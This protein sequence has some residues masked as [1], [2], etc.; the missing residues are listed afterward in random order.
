QR[1]DDSTEGGSGGPSTSAEESATEEEPTEE[2]PT[3]EEPT[4]DGGGGDATGFSED[5]CTTY[6]LSTFEEVLGDEIDPDQTYTSASSSGETGSVS[7]NFYTKDYWSL[8]LYVD[9]TDD[10]EFNIGWVEDEQV[11]QAEDGTYEV[12]D[13]TALGD[14]GYM[15]KSTDTSSYQTILINVAVAN[16]ELEAEASIDPAVHDADAAVA[17][18]EDLLSELYVSFAGY[19]M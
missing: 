3:E 4:D 16:I 5:I 10:P 18:L 14:T 12:T 17:M 13:Y 2:E 11:S 19:E 6:D 7:C 15:A 9:V 8:R 1:S